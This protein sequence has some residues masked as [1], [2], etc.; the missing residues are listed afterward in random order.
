MLNS[1]LIVLLLCAISAFFSLSEISLAAS[2]RIKLKLMAD[3]GNINAARVLKLQE[4][5]GRFFTVVQIG[6]NAVAILA[7]IVGESAFSPALQQFFIQFLSPYWAQQFASILSFIIV[8]SLFI[9]VADL[10]P[11]RIGMVKPEAIAIRIVNPMRFLLS[12]PQPVSLV[13]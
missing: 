4:M 6:L 10:T 11:K 2:R 5:P 12:R 13:L 3:E 9:L 7:G 1:L 8:T